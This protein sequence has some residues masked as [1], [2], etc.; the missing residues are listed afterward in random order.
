MKHEL[1]SVCKKSVWVTVKMSRLPKYWYVPRTC[2]VL[3]LRVKNKLKWVNQ[4]TIEV[5]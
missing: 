5:I 2:V 1:R 4:N 3:S